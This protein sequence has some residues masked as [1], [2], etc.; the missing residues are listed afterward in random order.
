MI[1]VLTAP[2]PPLLTFSPGCFGSL[3]G[4][5]APRAFE[6]KVVAIEI[7]TENEGQSFK[8]K[9]EIITSWFLVIYV[10]V[11]KKEDFILTSYLLIDNN[12]QE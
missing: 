11:A 9:R 12:Q 2:V 6:L 4:P 8:E 7:A 1:R 5:P 10:S 3:L